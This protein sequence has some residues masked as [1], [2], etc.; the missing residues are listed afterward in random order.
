MGKGAR[1]RVHHATKKQMQKEKNAAKALK[2]KRD[3]LIMSVIAIV[4]A[5]GIVAGALV[6]IF[7]YS[8]GKYLRDD[9]SVRSTTYELNNAEMTYLF[10]SNYVNFQNIYGEYF[11]EYTGVNPYDSLQDQAF[12]D[13]TTWFDYI[14]DTTKASTSQMISLAEKAT[15]EGMTLTDNDYE[16]IDGIIGLVNEYY[17]E[18]GVNEEDIRNTMEISRLA[19]NYGQKLVEDTVLTDEEI[20]EYY[21]ATPFAYQ[22]ASYIQYS[23]VYDID[24][25][26]GGLTQEEALAISENLASTTSEEEFLE[27][28]EE[29]MLAVNPEYTEEEIAS[30]LE[31]ITLEDV[32]WDGTSEGNQ[33]FDSENEVGDTFVF[34]DAETGVIEVAYLTKVAERSEEATVDFRQIYIAYGN[35]ET[36]EAGVEEANRIYDE[37]L[38]DPTEEKFVLLAQLNSEDTSTAANG[39]QVTGATALYSVDAVSEWLFDTSR[40]E[41]NYEK[42]ETDSGV[43]IV[44]YENAGEE[45]WIERVS[46]DLVA[47]KV[48]ATTDAILEEYPVEYNDSLLSNIPS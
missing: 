35:Y 26:E 8:N 5:I 39:G 25:M 24:D 2:D 40:A 1:S 30:S 7:Y 44:Y 21:D 13:T 18:D 11:Y 14:L 48:N 12:D 33:I 27:L 41:G 4:V 3:K 31:N 17:Y 22:T 20:Q 36:P 19:T 34:E 29:E 28:V 10:K 47:E 38:A 46:A 23:I 32:S 6:Y 9:V 15:A 43:Y 16:Y 42:I 37:F 45:Y